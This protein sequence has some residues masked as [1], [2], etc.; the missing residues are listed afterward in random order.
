MYNYSNS[1]VMVFNLND[2]LN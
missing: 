1:S 2:V